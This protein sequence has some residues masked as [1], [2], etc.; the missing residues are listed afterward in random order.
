MWNSWRILPATSSFW[1]LCIFA[2][3]Y[4]WRD[5]FITGVSFDS[6]LWIQDLILLPN[7]HLCHTVVWGLGQKI[8]WVSL[9]RHGGRGGWCWWVNWY[10]YRYVQLVYVVVQFCPWFKFYFPLFLVWFGDNEFE[11]KKNKIWTKV[12]RMNLNNNMYIWFIAKISSGVMTSFSH[13]RRPRRSMYH[14]MNIL[15]STWTN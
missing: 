3:I 10:L 6:L 7:L 8:I 11:T 9:W 14:W 5:L 12:N 2:T 15:I 4:H 1:K 13:H